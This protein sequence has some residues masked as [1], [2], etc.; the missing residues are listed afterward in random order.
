MMPSGAKVET[1]TLTA[2][3]SRQ[4]GGI[5]S[6]IPGAGPLAGGNSREYLPLRLLVAGKQVFDTCRQKYTCA[7]VGHS[8]LTS[9]LSLPVPGRDRRCCRRRTQLLD[10]GPRSSM[11]RFLRLGR[12]A[13]SPKSRHS[14]E[15]LTFLRRRDLADSCSHIRERLFVCWRDSRRRPPCWRRLSMR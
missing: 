11:C 5:K 6:I 14:S 12:L 4:R 1:I 10:W 13:R 2:S 9:S 15:W 8:R 7:R 3:S